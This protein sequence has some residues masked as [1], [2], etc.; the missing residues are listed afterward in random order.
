MSRT[1][2]QALGYQ[3]LIAYLNGECSLEGA[4]QLIQ[5]RTR[6]FA[7]RQHTWFRNLEEC[8]PIEITGHE[9]AEEVAARLLTVNQ[10]DWHTACNRLFVRERSVT[11]PS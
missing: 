1:A 8:Q 10:P 7:K 9:T 5:T 3:E 6:Q 2:R 4:I 11:H